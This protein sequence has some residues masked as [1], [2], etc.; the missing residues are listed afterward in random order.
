M[1][2]QGEEWG[3]SM[4]F[5]YFTDHI[6]EELG[7][8]VSHGRRHEFAAFGWKPEDVPDP[9][10]RATFERSILDWA[11]LGKEPH[12]GLLEWHKHLIALR[13]QVPALADGSFDHVHTTWDD[14][15][16]WFVLSRGDITIAA[17][18][19]AG[20]Q[21]VP[22]PKTARIVL[23][24]SDPEATGLDASAVRL[25]PDAVAVLGPAEPPA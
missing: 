20:P 14:G 25:G 6:D 11:E 1:L 9:Q 7:R 19:A 2:F 8:L 5:Q 21:S 24:A 4:P 13:R 16:H 18:L 15:R 12:A 3:A 17:N 23:L 10:D 22:V